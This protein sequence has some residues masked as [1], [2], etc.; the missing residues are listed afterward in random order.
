MA[1]AD[2]W[3]SYFSIE[4]NPIFLLDFPILLQ[5]YVN[6]PEYICNFPF[7]LVGDRGRIIDIGKVGPKLS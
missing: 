3:Q 5:N 7:H 4:W 1:Q 2:S 6:Y